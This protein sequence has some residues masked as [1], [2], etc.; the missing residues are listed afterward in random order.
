MS[1]M[2]IHIFTPAKQTQTMIE[3]IQES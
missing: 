2:W 3:N 1:E